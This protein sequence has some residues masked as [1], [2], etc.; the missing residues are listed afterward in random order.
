VLFDGAAGP[1]VSIAE[2]GGYRVLFGRGGPT[3][4]NNPTAAIS[5]VVNGAV[6]PTGYTV[7]SGDTGGV[8]F[9]VAVP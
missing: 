2:P 5:V 3:C 1:S 8:R 4:A 7:A 9:D 6:F